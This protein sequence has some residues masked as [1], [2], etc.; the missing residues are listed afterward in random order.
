MLEGENI[1][2]FAKDWSE[3]PTSNNHVMRILAR[4]NKVVWLNSIGVRKPSLTSGRDLRKIV[5]K[6]RRF[7]EGPV[8]VAD[9]LWV[10]TPL[11]LPFPHSEWASAINGQILRRT[12]AFLRRRLEI[13]RF[14][15]WT[16]LPNV[17]RYLGR[18]GESLAVY[19]CTD[20]FS[21]FSYLD[22]ARLRAEEQELC[23]RADVVFT[24]AGSLWER[25]RPLNPETH[26]ALH[27]VDHRHFAAALATTTATPADLADAPR[28]ILG[29]FGL[30]HD[31]I[32][33]DLIAYLAE[34]RP[35]WTVALIGKASVDVSRLQRYPN[36]RILGRKPYAD[37]PGYCKAFSVGLLPFVIN[38]LTT[39]VNP[40]KLREYLSAGLPVVST[41]L[42]ETRGYDSCR[43]A[44][45]PAEFLA[46][47]EQ[48]IA[49]D[50]P[51][52]RL[53][54]S[55]AVAGETWE[56]RVNEIGRI[57]HEVAQ[58]RSRYVQ[59]EHQSALVHQHFQSVR[60]S[61]Q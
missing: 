30:I 40:I 46:A 41:D 26:L 47:C 32:D 58:R 5:H 50:T 44:R 56:A 31:W 34:R 4:G 24:T 51:S 52:L 61:Q 28:P 22:G 25:R 21:Q 19:Y 27:G 33:L 38:E 6:L 35:D 7:A 18:L 9:G 37:L 3:D 55:Q 20:E 2:C 42:P 8:Q 14:Q 29:F 17:A 15:L 54:R 23:R 39:N 36:I 49:A 12:I 53:T 1:I 13:D 10:F 45:S 43:I 59:R 11:A 57:V 60:R 48:A 16:F